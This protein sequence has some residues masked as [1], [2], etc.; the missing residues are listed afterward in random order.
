MRDFTHAGSR[1]MLLGENP[2]PELVALLSDEE[3]VTKATPPAFLVHT[4][5]DP[6]VPVENSLKFADA[7]RKA[8]VPFELNIYEH[9]P[10]GFGMGK[11]DP[12][13][14]TWLGRCATWL[15]VHHFV[16]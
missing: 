11:G 6:G 7:L 15:R 8:H 9:G 1:K 4:A 2:T 16:G 12:I 5:D 3:Q 14:T 13:L 10:H